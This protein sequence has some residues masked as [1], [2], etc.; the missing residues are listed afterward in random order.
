MKILLC[1]TCHIERIVILSS[2]KDGHNDARFSSA[3]S[4]QIRF[5]STGEV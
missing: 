3:G 5:I 4:G 1:L 2:S